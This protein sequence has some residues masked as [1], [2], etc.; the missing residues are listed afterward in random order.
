MMNC[1]QVLLSSSTCAATHWYAVFL[2]RRAKLDNLRVR[3]YSTSH[4]RQMITT[5]DKTRDL[6]L[7]IGRLVSFHTLTL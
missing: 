1:F 7:F 5:S 2:D 3:P 4:N 6:L